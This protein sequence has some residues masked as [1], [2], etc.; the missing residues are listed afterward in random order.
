[1]TDSNANGKPHLTL[2]KSVKDTLDQYIEVLQLYIK[3][4][5]LG[6]YTPETR[7]FFSNRVVTDA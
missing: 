5:N 1:M 4:P 7:K 6:V 3:D 2:L